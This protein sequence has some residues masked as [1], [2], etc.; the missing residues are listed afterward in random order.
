MGIFGKFA[1]DFLCGAT[2]GLS[3]K[4]GI[5]ESGHDDE[6]GEA[7]SVYSV[8]M[9]ADGIYLT[10]SQLQIP[11]SDIAAVSN[12]SNGLQTF[13]FRGGLLIFTGSFCD[14]TGGTL[15]FTGLCGYTGKTADQLVSE[16]D[17][18]LVAMID[19]L[20]WTSQLANTLRDKDENLLIDEDNLF[21]LYSMM[22]FYLQMAE[23]SEI[24]QA[25]D[26]KKCRNAI[27]YFRKCLEVQFSR[28]DENDAIVKDTIEIGLFA[29]SGITVHGVYEQ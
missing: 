17:E 27:E 24:I 29:L 4:L 13:T 3:N 7:Q 14:T 6:N 23:S 22:L 28:I 25:S 11:W 5:T 8:Y 15:D 19:D 2:F 1:E 20:R 16:E 21:Q 18:N 10:A 9:G 12:L 26:T